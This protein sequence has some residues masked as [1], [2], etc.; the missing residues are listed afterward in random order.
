MRIDTVGITA[1][2]SA[3]AEFQEELVESTYR[4]AAEARERL[5]AG[6]GQDAYQILNQYMNRNLER[7]LSKVKR[8]ADTR[9]AGVA[10]HILSHG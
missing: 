5:D 8:D 10:S 9:P 4:I 3:W 7:A 1:I 6:Q 2:R